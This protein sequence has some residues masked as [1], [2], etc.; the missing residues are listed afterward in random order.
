MQTNEDLNVLKQKGILDIHNDLD[1]NMIFIKTP[2]IF[3]IKKSIDF[4]VQS[5][6]I[7]QGHARSIYMCL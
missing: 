5:I 1:T 7:I 6:I 2:S 3:N 4:R